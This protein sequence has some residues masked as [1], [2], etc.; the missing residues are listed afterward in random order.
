MAK[1]TI[2]GVEVIVYDYKEDQALC[3]VPELDTKNWY[4]QNLIEVKHD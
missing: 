1:A 3:Y 4:K 2:N